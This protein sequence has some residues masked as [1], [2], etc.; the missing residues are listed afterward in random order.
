MGSLRSG[1]GAWLV[2][3][4]LVSHRLQFGSGSRPCRG[5]AADG[6]QEGSK[7]NPVQLVAD[8]ALEPGRQPIANQ[9][10]KDETD[11]WF[12]DRERVLNRE[13]RRQPWT[14]VRTLARRDFATASMRRSQS[15]CR[16]HRM[17]TQTPV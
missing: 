4:P 5:V 1:M 11:G 2:L 9:P 7:G 17:S 6:P 16:V 10:W 15:R 3:D 12:R 8:M 14:R 13:P